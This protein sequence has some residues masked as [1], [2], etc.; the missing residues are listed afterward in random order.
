MWQNILRI[1]NQFIL[2]TNLNLVDTITGI[3]VATARR[4]IGV[5]VLCV[6][7]T[8]SMKSILIPAFEDHL[9]LLLL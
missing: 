3:C 8:W 5:K 6:V 1:T 4:P 7:Q 2:M 9:S